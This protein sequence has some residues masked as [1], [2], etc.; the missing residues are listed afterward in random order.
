MTVTKDAA[1]EGDV[2]ENFTILGLEEAEEAI[3]TGHP[4][5]IVRDEKTLKALQN[6]HVPLVAITK[7]GLDDLGV[8]A[9]NFENAEVFL[10][11]DSAAY[12][13]DACHHLATELY[14]TAK[15][16]GIIDLDKYWPEHPEH[17]TLSDWIE[18][19]GGNVDLFYDFFS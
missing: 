5:V 9:T 7:M 4:V 8:L 12:W 1:A 13:R 2:R 16:V 14:G 15:Y 19:G 3:G 11:R 10:L 17:F 6:W 18:K